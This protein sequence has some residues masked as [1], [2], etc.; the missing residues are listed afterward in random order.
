MQ[1]Q[2]ESEHKARSQVLDVATDRL[3][4]S[5]AIGQDE[6]AGG[7][8]VIDEV[9]LDH[10]VV[11][12]L[13]DLDGNVHHLVVEQVVK[14]RRPDVGVDLGAQPGADANGAEVVVDV[15]G[16]DD[17][18][19]RHLPGKEFPELALLST[20]KEW[21]QLRHRPGLVVVYTCPMT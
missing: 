13:P 4:R 16:D 14:A 17:G 2:F 20:S 18:A 5:S 19:C 8:F 10:E 12:V 7:P 11:L 21:I 3:D 1:H 15:L 6:I 9:L